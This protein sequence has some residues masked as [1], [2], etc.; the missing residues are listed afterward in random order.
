MLAL[1]G[2][3]LLGGIFVGAGVS[4]TV[5]GGREVWV[6]E[7]TVGVEAVTTVGEGDAGVLDPLQAATN[8]TSKNMNRRICGVLFVAYIRGIRVNNIS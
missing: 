2:G 1:E 3:V 7:R 5:V 8:N 4:E 6:E